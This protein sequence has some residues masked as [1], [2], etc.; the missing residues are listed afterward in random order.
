MQ[1]VSVFRRVLAPVF[2]LV[3]AAALFL[4]AWIPPVSAATLNTVASRY[5]FTELPIAL[6]PGLPMHTV[7]PVN[8]LYYPIRAWISSVGAAIALN[9]IEGTG[10]PD[11]LCL[12]DTRSDSVIV[13]PAP[14]TGN[15]YAPFVLNPAPLPMGP[16]I[17]PMGCTPGDFNGDGLMDLLV[18]YWGRTPILFMHQPGVKGL[19][20]ATFVPE[21]LVPQTP[22][23]DGT[24]HG[25][26]WN[27][28]AVN[29][30][31]F[32]GDGKVDVGIFNYFPDSA[33][34]DP[35]GDPNVHMN[36]SMSHAQNAGGAHIFRQI[37]ATGGAHPSV[38]F[39]EQPDAVP[40]ADATGWTLGASSADLDGDLLPELYLANDFG[41]DHLFHNV[42]TPGHIKFALVRGSRGAYTPKSFV[43]GNDSFKGMS[44]DFG[45]LTDSGKFDMFVSN[46]TTSWGLEESNMVWMNTAAN[47]AAA[48]TALD[49]GI[50]PFNQKARETGM[51]W[52][53]W[54]WDAKIAD[55][56]NSGYPAVVQCDGFVKGNISRWNW[57]QE[58]AMSN[59]LM[60]E[61]PSMWPKAEPGDD[62]AGDQT[63]AFYA[64]VGDGT[65]LNVSSQLGLAVPIPTRGIAVADTTGGGAQDF[66]VARQWGA[67]AFYQN[68]LKG[69][70]DFLG[71]RLFRP[72]VGGDGATVGAPAYGSQVL[73]RMSDGRTQ[74]AQLDGGGGHSG[75]RSFDI[76]FGLGAAGAQPVSATISWRDLNGGMHSQTMNLTSGWHDLMLTSIA[77]EVAPV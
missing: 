67:P 54:G 71:L 73:I 69:K 75:R 36:H 46:I 43:L 72:A 63:L 77:K 10:L 47:E 22:S 11:D 45:D 20:N 32:D 12:V 9:D 30:A 29:V 5:R 68:D 74:L 7:R 61:N 14:G 26:L 2:V 60:L 57:L 48:K 27:T 41:P 59:D 64:P 58:L 65:F 42:S 19:S 3:L 51:A 1:P 44:I 17:A 55:F 49:Q 76:Y 38:S 21:E 56:D 70:G 8:P 15:R 31:D 16:A 40:V 6:P 23:P 18:Y 52:T 24:Y 37:A 35:N 39:Q 66:A 4:V 13:T 28:N 53:G 33:V 34:L 25:P 50:A 62:I